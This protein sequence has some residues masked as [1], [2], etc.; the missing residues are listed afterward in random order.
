M[1]GVGGIRTPGACPGARGVW[2]DFSELVRAAAP[3]VR[4]ACTPAKVV[5]RRSTFRPHP[6]QQRPPSGRCVR[7]HNSR[8]GRPGSCAPGARGGG[9]LHDGLQLPGSVDPPYPS[10]CIVE[11]HE[12][13]QGGAHLTA[14]S[15]VRFVT[16]AAVCAFLMTG[17]GAPACTKKRTTTNVSDVQKS[18]ESGGRFDCRPA[19]TQNPGRRTCGARL[20]GV[21]VVVELHKKNAAPPA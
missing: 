12:T 3:T 13:P 18:Q 21:C 16:F 7:C 10:L 6:G 2:R 15:C 14:G 1:Y 4:P 20:A 11:T 5:G 9:G 8:T 17:P 19:E